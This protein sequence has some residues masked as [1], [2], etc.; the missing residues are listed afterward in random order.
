MADLLAPFGSLWALLCSLWMPLWRILM[1]LD[2]LLAPFGCL[3]CNPASVGC[4]FGCILIPSDTLL[5]PFDPI[6][7]IWVPFWLH[8]DTFGYPFDPIW[9]I[10]VPSCLTFYCF[11]TKSAAIYSFLKGLGWVGE[12]CIIS[13]RAFSAT[14]SFSIKLT[15][16]HGADLLCNLDM[17][18]APK[19]SCCNQMAVTQRRKLLYQ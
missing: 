2:I 18:S 6:W 11:W 16:W 5:T 9:S 3:G 13:T 1:P 4:P 8:F 17:S 7:S 12:K 15:D 19:L 10:W 14:H